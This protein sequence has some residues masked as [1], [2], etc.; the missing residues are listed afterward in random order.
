[1]TGLRLTDGLST[2]DLQV[3]SGMS[4]DEVADPDGM[5]RLL[6]ADLIERT[7]RGIVATEEGRLR[8]NAVIGMLL[9]GSAAA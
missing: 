2:A 1:M 5:R 3:A 4:M 8:L 6:E 7:D 9:S